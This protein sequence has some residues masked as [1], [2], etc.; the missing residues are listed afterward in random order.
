LLQALV[1]LARATKA[2]AALPPP[3]PALVK[4]RAGSRA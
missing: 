4:A 3:P 2:D 1:K